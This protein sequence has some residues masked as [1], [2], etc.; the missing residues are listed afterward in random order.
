MITIKP[1]GFIQKES[2]SSPISTNEDK[3]DIKTGTSLWTGQRN[4]EVKSEKF[5]RRPKR[6]ISFTP[7][8]INPK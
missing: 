8:F 2:L 5:L 6:N 7:Q 3:K 4:S 1:N